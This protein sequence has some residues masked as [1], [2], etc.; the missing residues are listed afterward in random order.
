MELPL[1]L[2][3]WVLGDPEHGTE[4]AMAMEVAPENLLA[5]TYRACFPPHDLRAA[6]LVKGSLNQLTNQ[7]IVANLERIRERAKA[8]ACRTP[9]QKG[10]REFWLP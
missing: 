4:L 10:H 6:S 7:D 1:E 3:L 9:Q 2:W 8:T 5:K